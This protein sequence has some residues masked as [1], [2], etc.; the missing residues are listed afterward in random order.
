[1][2]DRAARVQVGG[3][4]ALYAGGFRVELGECGYASSSA[5]GLLQLMAQLSRWLGERGLDGTDLTPA[6]VE[7]FLQTRSSAGYRR[8][9]SARSLR[10]LLDYLRGLGVAPA[11][12]PGALDDP[13]A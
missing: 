6:V 2:K 12:A 11:C 10:P 3:P 5:A 9:L 4:L 7:E 1:M 8:W 13:L